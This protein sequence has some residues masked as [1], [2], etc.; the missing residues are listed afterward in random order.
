MNFN[1]FNQSP[2]LQ[3]QVASDFAQAKSLLS[4]I[5]QLLDF[6]GSEL[7]FE[8]SE[9]TKIRGMKMSIEGAMDISTPEEQM[10]F[11]IM[12]LTAS[13]EFM[14]LHN[15]SHCKILNNI[16]RGA[17]ENPDT[18]LNLKEIA[19]AAVSHATRT[20]MQ[21]DHAAACDRIQIKLNGAQYDVLQRGK[22][23]LQLI[24][25]APGA[26]P[27]TIM[28]AVA[29]VETMVNP[30]LDFIADSVRKRNAAIIRSQY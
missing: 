18:A 30:V 24:T 27:A 9:L 3:E 16:V 1:T 4:M 21:I 28:Q 15:E 13:H 19:V 7:V 5:R 17:V 23:I 2:A 22:M 12:L 6:K 10:N 25:T 20:V 29:E 14:K 26:T 8:A 11:R